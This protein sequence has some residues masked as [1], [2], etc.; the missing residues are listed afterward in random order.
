M[1]ELLAFL[2]MDWEQRI[3]KLKS[4]SKAKRK[5]Y[6]NRVVSSAEAFPFVL[7]DADAEDLLNFVIWLTS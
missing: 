4:M 7:D 2:N 5:S 1:A 6:M 3:N